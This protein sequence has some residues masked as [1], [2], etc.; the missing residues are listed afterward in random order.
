M[1]VTSFLLKPFE[2]VL[3]IDSGHVNVHETAAIEGR[4]HKLYTAQIF[5]LVF[6][7]LKMVYI[8][9]P[10]ECRTIYLKK[11]LEE[12]YKTFKENN[13]L[14]YIDG[15]RLTSALTSNE[16]DMSPKEYASLSDIFTIWDVKKGL[17]CG[18]TV[19]FNDKNLTKN[20]RYHIKNKEAFFAKGLL[21]GIQFEE[22]FKSN[23]YFKIV[24]HENALV[25]I[26]TKFLKEIGIKFYMESPYC[27]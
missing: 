16:N 18:E 10:T 8:S 7:M 26:V 27:R 6:N 19:V 24:N 2:V 12:I 13:L 4:G 17:L 11:E 21:L 5:F 1:V 23:L 20:F 22:L 9:N 3:N 25:G 15:T 14:L